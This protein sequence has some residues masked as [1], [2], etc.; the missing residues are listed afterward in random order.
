MNIFGVVDNYYAK[1]RPWNAQ[2]VAVYSDYVSYIFENIY[3]NYIA[4]IFDQ[5]LREN[6]CIKQ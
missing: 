1:M 6:L 3:E 2:L 4:Q 5:S